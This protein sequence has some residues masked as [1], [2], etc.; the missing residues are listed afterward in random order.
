MNSES[1]L[2]ISSLELIA[3]AIEL[4]SYNNRKKFKFVILHLANAIELILKDLLIKNNVSI[5]SVPNSS[6]T[7]NI[8]KAFE[9][10]GQ[11]GIHI[12]ERPVIELLID[13]RNNIQHKF[14]FPDEQM[15]N[16]YLEN[17]IS[18]FKRFI[19]DEY[20]LNFLDALEL[21]LPEN[22]IDTIKGASSIEPK[23]ISDSN[24]LM[25]NDVNGMV[26]VSGKELEPLTALEQRLLLLFYER[27]NQILDK[28]TILSFVWGDDYKPSDDARLEKLI[29]RLRQR[30]EFDPENPLF[31]TT[32]RGRGYRFNRLAVTDDID[33]AENNVSAD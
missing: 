19:E 25:I 2:F 22:S 15:V 21:Y 20:E 16:Y 6:Q 3:H 32:I 18:F 14:G 1:P 8:W 26:Y 17:V 10:L 29:S 11:L 13:D 9:E 4:H 23:N 24:G 12:P 27:N 31:L 30:I 28:P 33:T 7:I 5:Y